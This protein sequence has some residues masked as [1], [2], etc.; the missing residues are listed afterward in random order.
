MRLIS[1]ASPELQEFRKENPLVLMADNGLIYKPL[2]FQLGLSVASFYPRMGKS[3][4]PA[5]TH[6]VWRRKKNL[7]PRRNHTMED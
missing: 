6:K 3:L 7:R 4:K 5:E 1:S 2:P